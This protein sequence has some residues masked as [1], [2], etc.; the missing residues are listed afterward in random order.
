MTIQWDRVN[1]VERN[2]HVN[3]YFFFFYPTSNPSRVN[4][5]T[6]LGTEDSYRMLSITALQPLTS[7]TFEV[8]ALNSRVRDPGAIATI[9]VSTTAP[10]SK[11]VLKSGDDVSF[12][13]CIILCYF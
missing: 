3:S 6:V 1:C 4:G 11:I 13:L 5:R 8:E 12:S 9:S 7:Y 2:G 10:Q